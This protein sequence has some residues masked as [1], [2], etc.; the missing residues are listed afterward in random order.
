MSIVDALLPNCSDVPLDELANATF[1]DGG[2]LA[3]VS[4]VDQ[5]LMAFARRLLADPVL[6]AEA[7]VQ[8]PR[9]KQR[10]A[11]LLAILSHSLC[12]QPPGRLSGPVVL[13][14]FDVDLA[15]QLRHLELQ[16]RRRMGLHA[17]N[18]LFSAHAHSRWRPASASR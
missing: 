3:S 7:V 16:N 10:S 1:I 14:G 11:L 5:L 12:R 13:I 2:E 18:P 15:H 8:L 9:A 17:G 4:A 6:G